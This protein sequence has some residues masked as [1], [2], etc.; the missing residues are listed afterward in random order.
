[1]T[2]ITF[3]MKENEK[4]YLDREGAYLIADKMKNLQ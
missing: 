1:M 3:G 2:Y 4:E